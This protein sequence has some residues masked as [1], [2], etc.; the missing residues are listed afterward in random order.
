M[1]QEFLTI[2]THQGLYVY[3]CLP[4]GVASAPAIFQKR[5]DT[6]IQGTVRVACYIDGILVSSATEENHIETLKEVFIRLEKHGFR[7]KLEKCEFLQ[8]SIEYLGHII[9]KEGIKPVP[10][11][12]EAIVNAQS[13]DNVQQLRSFLGL[14]NYIKN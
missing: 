6:V 12:V 14:T 10:S 3:N 11:K 13:P 5:M 2:N 9:C 7:L 4:F 1:N 8:P